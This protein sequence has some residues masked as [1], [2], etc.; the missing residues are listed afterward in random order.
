MQGEQAVIDII[1]RSREVGQSY[2]TS[3]ATT[4]HALAAGFT[5]VWRR[6]PDL[7]QPAA[8]APLRLLTERT[9]PYMCAVSSSLHS[10]I[11]MRP[12]SP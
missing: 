1:P 8:P 2:I 3:V 11:S 6:R 9:Q 7:V 5:I 12:R 4:L 10:Y